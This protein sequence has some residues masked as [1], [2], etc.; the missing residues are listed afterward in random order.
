MNRK[1]G[2]L[3]GKL[4][5]T[6]LLACLLMSYK[7]VGYEKPAKEIP[8][9]ILHVNKAVKDV[10]I[11][12]AFWS[13]KLKLWSN[14]TVNDVL[15]KFEGNYDINN[16]RKGLADDYKRLGR[17]RNALLNFDLVAQGK[18]GIKQ[19]DG[20]EWYDGLIYESIRG[21]SDFLIRYPDKKIEAKIDGYIDRIEA[22][23]NSVGDGY[24][25]THTLLVEPEHRWGLKGGF[26][27]G[28]HDV[29]NS[30]ALIE[31]AVHYYMATGKTRLL[32][33]A[34]RCAN[35]ICRE[36]G[37]APKLNVIPGHALAEEAMMK[38]Y[39]LFRDHPDLKNKM[40]EKVNE[41]DYYDMAKFWIESRGHNCGLPK[42]NIWSYQEC[43][44]WIKTYGLSDPEYKKCRPSWGKYDQ[45]SLPFEQQ[46]TIEGHA[47]RATLFA[48]GVTTVALENK[49]SRYVETSSALWDNMV[50]KR[51]YL[52]GGVGAFRNEEMFGPDYIVP[53]DGYCETCAA[54]GSGFFSS[55]MAELHG[56]GKYVDEFERTLYNNVLSGISL[57]GDHY[58][59]E[60]SL[61]GQ[62]I[63]RWNW[64]ECPCC[65]PMFLKLVSELPEYIYSQE[66]NAIFVKLF[67]GSEAK[68]KFD[69]GQNVLVK[70]TTN[71]PW[72][73][74]ITINIEPSIEKEFAVKVR[75]PGW[76]QGI[77]NPYGL[78]KS[79]VKS[80]AS[81]KINGKDIALKIADGFVSI[82]RKWAKGD[83]IDLTLPI[84][85]RFVFANE[86]V[87]NLSGMVAMASGPLVYGLEEF[88]N[89]GLNSYKIDVNTPIKINFKKDVLN[90]VNVITGMTITDKGTKVM[91]TAV[92]SNTLNNRNPGNAF[93]V[94]MPVKI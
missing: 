59:Y 73:G 29:Y 57:T 82:T 86:K 30:G 23:Q 16:A 53:S 44:K 91:F 46:K 14:V 61:V 55:R 47:V 6:M 92:P 1:I 94:W 71:Y 38:L 28:Q 79:K 5:A 15:N 24:I 34:I 26:E 76:A 18:R 2:L 37:P 36:I 12:D 27:R 54:V 87:K 25:N 72:E 62:D 33:V 43:D 52:T 77:E 41:K 22:A 50:G 40:S 32:N 51:M 67:I 49:D 78:Y 4:L 19:H 81:I 3:K 9:S 58:A 8:G 75:I 64:H 93:K 42:W 90:G 56:E 80:K 88:D 84:E 21:A 31:A 83:V 7:P 48:T 74:H 20:P 35:N 85:P 39:W 63:K 60:N 65:P 17:T 68:I 66:G 70:Q 10:I 89:P 69:N 13:P 11:N 45:D